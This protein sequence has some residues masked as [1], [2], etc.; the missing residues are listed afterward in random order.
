[1]TNTNQIIIPICSHCELPANNLAPTQ[2][3]NM[4]TPTKTSLHNQPLPWRKTHSA[5]KKF[6]ERKDKKAQACATD[7]F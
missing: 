6:R 3:F 4:R 1:M 5:F 2:P 7:T